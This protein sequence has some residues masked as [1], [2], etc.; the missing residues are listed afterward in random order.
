MP[1]SLMEEGVA[2]KLIK[3][4]RDMSASKR[5]VASVSASKGG[6]AFVCQ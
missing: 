4:Q 1:F 6:V 5:G 2:F 3:I